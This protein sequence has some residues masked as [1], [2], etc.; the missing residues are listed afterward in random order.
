MFE[1]APDGGI[2]TKSIVCYMDAVETLKNPEQILKMEHEGHLLVKDVKSKCVFDENIELIDVKLDVFG[3]QE[4]LFYST[5]PSLV[6][7]VRRGN[8]ILKKYNQDG[9]HQFFMG[10]RGL[11][12][13]FD[14]RLPFISKEERN[15]LSTS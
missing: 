5:F 14:L 1:L 12:K 2:L 4:D 11:M 6:K 15:S 10:R 8:T 3:P 13:F 9:T 7:N